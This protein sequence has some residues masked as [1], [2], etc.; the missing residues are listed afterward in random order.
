VYEEYVILAYMQGDHDN[1]TTA[2]WNVEIFTFFSVTL[3]ASPVQI[4]S[5]GCGVP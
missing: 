1:M 4:C 3:S 2:A 5:P